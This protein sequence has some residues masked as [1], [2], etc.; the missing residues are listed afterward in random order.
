MDK[1]IAMTAGN[2]G[3][4]LCLAINY[5]ARAEIVD[6]VRANCHGG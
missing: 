6:A 3:L 1:T 5:G 2:H 4:R